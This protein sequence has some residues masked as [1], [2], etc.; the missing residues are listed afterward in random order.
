MRYNNLLKGLW[1]CRLCKG[2][3]F[4]GLHVYQ[5]ISVFRF[6]LKWT[7]PI[8]PGSQAATVGCDVAGALLGGGGGGAFGA[9]D[10]QRGC[11]A[12]QA[13]CSAA[14]WWRLTGPLVTTCVL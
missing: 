12:L 13:A 10:E 9:K 8:D 4:K 5:S 7:P 14:T 2:F 1:L 11:T 3:V 6:E